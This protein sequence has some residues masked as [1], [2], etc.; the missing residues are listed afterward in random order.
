MSIERIPEA[1][2]SSRLTGPLAGWSY[3][4]GA[5]AR[6]FRT[7][8]WQRTLLLANAIGFAAEA[9]GHHPDLALGYGRLGVRLSTH[10]AGGVTER[11]FALAERI[12]ALA[13]WQPEPGSAL[14]GSPAPW[15]R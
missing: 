9:A 3:T 12:E 2:I 6:E 10:D 11:D 7:G 1:R 14:G 5:L 8:D 13:T 4:G 15:F